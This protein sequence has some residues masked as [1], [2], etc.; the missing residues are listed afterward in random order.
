MATWMAVAVV[1]VMGVLAPPAAAQTSSTPDCAAKLAPCAPYINTTGMPPDT[2]CGP[3]KEAVQNELKCLCGLYASPEIF[4][5]FNINV[6]QALGVSKRC[7]LSDTTE[8][9]KG[10][11]PTQSHP[12]SPSGGGKNSG[13]RTLSVGFPGLMSLFLALWAVLA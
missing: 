4:K 6:T 9:C 3:I 13:H 12:G 11:A 10:L 5:A 1:A 2:C 8:A 7:G